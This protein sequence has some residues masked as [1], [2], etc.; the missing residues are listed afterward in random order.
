MKILEVIRCLNHRLKP[1]LKSLA[2][3]LT[4]APRQDC[5]TKNFFHCQLINSL[6]LDCI[7]SLY[8]LLN[9]YFCVSVF[10]PLSHLE[11]CSGIS[12]SLIIFIFL[13]YSLFY[14][15]HL[16]VLFYQRCTSASFSNQDQS[17]LFSGSR[18]SD[19]SCGNWCHRK[20]GK[21]VFQVTLQ[22]PICCNF[23]MLTSASKIVTQ[24]CVR[25]WYSASLRADTD[26][27]TSFH[28]QKV[29]AKRLC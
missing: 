24:F 11:P 18:T 4:L 16:H 13:S 23:N 22:S 2:Y 29:S 3:K 26:S 15:Q 19:L 1:R 28:A 20:Q 6:L 10:P 8:S 27:T 25:H 21:K 12:I 9:V 5:T 14:I 7:Y 17:R